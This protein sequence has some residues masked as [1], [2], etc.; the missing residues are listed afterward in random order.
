MMWKFCGM[1]QFPHSL[2]RFARNYA[3]T[4]PFHKISTPRHWVKLRYFT[5]CLTTRQELDQD[6]YVKRNF[7]LSFR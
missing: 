1:T 3:E 7:E 5:Q 4:M 2:G 6:V